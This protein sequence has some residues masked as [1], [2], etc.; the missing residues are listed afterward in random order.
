[1]ILEAWDVQLQ[2]GP[3]VFSLGRMLA[4]VRVLSSVS[5]YR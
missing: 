2:F 1:M 4:G 3:C 5:V